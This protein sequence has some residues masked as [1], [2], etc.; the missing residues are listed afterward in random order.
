MT[1]R[2]KFVNVGVVQYIHGALGFPRLGLWDSL[3]MC[4][5]T[6]NADFGLFFSGAVGLEPFETHL[7]I[8]IQ[9]QVGVYLLC[10]EGA[11]VP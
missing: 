8:Q 2:H 3:S 6:S 4:V 7:G 5:F 1:V 10:A 9:K 11:Q